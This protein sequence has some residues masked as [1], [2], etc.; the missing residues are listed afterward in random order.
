[1]M[2]PPPGAMPPHSD[3]TS[4]LQA[5]RN[6]NTS[7]R[8]RIGRSTSTVGAAAGAAAPGVAVAAAAG[9][10]PAAGA[11]VPPLAA[12]TACWQGAETFALFFSRHCSAGAPPVGTPAQT[13]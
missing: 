1:M 13:F 9:A 4:P 2:R 5:D 7:S 3:R 6:T 11:V 8:G 10:P 12:L